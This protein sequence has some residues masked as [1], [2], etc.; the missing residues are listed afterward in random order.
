TPQGMLRDCIKWHAVT[1]LNLRQKELDAAAASGSDGTKKKETRDHILN[2]SCSAFYA[3]AEK[4][5]LSISQLFHAAKEGYTYWE[6]HR[7]ELKQFEGSGVPIH[8]FMDTRAAG[9]LQGAN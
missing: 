3:R 1:E 6:T 2:V 4:L 5:S 9:A 7:A 8:V